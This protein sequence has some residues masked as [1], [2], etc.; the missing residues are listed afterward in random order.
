MAAPVGRQPR[1]RRRPVSV[2]LGLAGLLNRY[3]RPRSAERRRQ[4]H[5]LNDGVG[6]DPGP[7]PSAAD[8]AFVAAPMAGPAPAPGPG[9]A[10]MPAPGP[11][12]LPMTETASREQRLKKRPNTEAERPRSLSQ[13]GHLLPQL[14]S[15]LPS[16]I[17][18][19]RAPHDPAKITAGTMEAKKRGTL[20]GPQAR[21]SPEAPVTL[22]GWLDKQGSERLRLWKTRWFVLSEYCLY[23]Y[24]DAREDKLLGS[25][26]LPSYRVC[27]VSAEDRVHRKFSFR[28]E[29]ANM[30]TY[31]FACDTKEK[32]TE[33][34]NAIS[35]ASI[36]QKDPGYPSRQ[37]SDRP[38]VGSLEGSEAGFPRRHDLN[39]SRESVGGRR[40]SRQPLYANAPPKPRRLT[41]S[42]EASSSPEP[43]DRLADMTAGAP[44]P[45]RR[46]PV[47]RRTP[48]AYAA[49][50][51][52]ARVDYED[53]YNASV[54]SGSSRD[55]SRAGEL[56]AHARESYASSA[57]RST[58]MSGELCTPP[59]AAPRG[60]YGH[61][62]V[63]PEHGYPPVDEYG[64]G[65]AAPPRPH[66][67]DFLEWERNAG[68][69]ASAGR[70]PAPAAR[71]KSSLAR[72]Q[73]PANDYWSEEGYAN[74][75][76]QAAYSGG[77]MLPG[78]AGPGPRLSP[79]PLPGS[80]AGPP[81]GAATLPGH[82]A[83]V[84]PETPPPAGTHS[85]GRDLE[86]V[87]RGSGFMR[88]ASAR[89]ARQKARELDMMNTSLPDDPND[90]REGT[91]RKIQQREE[92]MKRLLEWKQRMLQ[93]PLTRKSPKLTD[94]AARFPPDQYKRR[95]RQELERSEGNRTP[96]PQTVHGLPEADSRDVREAEFSPP[97]AA[98]Q[99]Y[100]NLSYRMGD[101]DPWSGRHE[102]PSPA[103]R[104]VPVV[105]S[106][107]ETWNTAMTSPAH[108]QW[109]ASGVTSP[110]NESWHSAGVSSPGPD[111]WPASVTSPTA[112]AWR[113]PTPHKPDNRATA[114]SHDHHPRMKTNADFRN[115]D[116]S[117]GTLAPDG[118]QQAHS[119]YSSQKDKYHHELHNYDRFYP[120]KE[121]VSAQRRAMAPS[122]N[123]LP[124][125]LVSA[126]ELEAAAALT[127]LRR[128]ENASLGK[129]SDSG[130]DTLRADM[131]G[132]EAPARAQNGR[133]SA[134]RRSAPLE[135][136]RRSAGGGGGWAAADWHDDGD[137]IDESRLVKEFSYEYVKPEQPPSAAKVP[138]KVLPKRSQAPRENTAAAAESPSQ[139]S[140]TP[141]KNLVQE[142][143]K[144][145]KSR[146][147]E[148][149]NSVGAEDERLERPL[150]P[151]KTQAEVAEAQVSQLKM[152]PID[153]RETEATTVTASEAQVTTIRSLNSSSK[154]ARS[155]GRSPGGR[156]ARSQEETADRSLTYSEGSPAN[157]L[158]LRDIRSPQDIID[159]RK[160][161]SNLR[162]FALDEDSP[163]DPEP[164]SVASAN[165]TSHNEP[166]APSEP[167]NTS[168]E[169][170]LA[171]FESGQLSHEWTPSRPS[172]SHDL[173]RVGSD[174]D[175]GDAERAG[176]E[177]SS[178][179]MA[180]VLGDLRRSAD[181]SAAAETR[182][183][184]Q[185]T[186]ESHWSPPGPTDGQWN[187]PSPHAT[188]WTPSGPRTTPAAHWDPHGSSLVP[189]PRRNGRDV[190]PAAGAAAHPPAAVDNSGMAVTRFGPGDGGVVLAPSPSASQSSRR[191]EEPRSPPAVP[192]KPARPPAP[193]P[194]SSPI[195]ANQLP[196]GGLMLN[197]SAEDQYLVMSPPRK[198]AE[199]LSE[200]TPPVPS[201]SRQTSAASLP[202]PPAAPPP[203]PP[204]PPPLRPPVQAAGSQQDGT[205][206]EMNPNVLNLSFEASQSMFKKLSNH[207]LFLESNKYSEVHYEYMAP[208]GRGEPVYMEVPSENGDS[209]G[210][211]SPVTSSAAPTTTTPT[212]AT[213]SP[214]KTPTAENK[215]DNK[216]KAESGKKLKNEKRKTEK[217][218]SS[219][220]S[221][222]SDADDEG[223]KEPERPRSRRFSLS[224]TFRPASYYLQMHDDREQADSS[225]SDL[226]SPP[227]IPMSP[228]PM[229]ELQPTE[230][231]SGQFSYDGTGESDAPPYLLN[232]LLAAHSAQ[233]TSVGGQQV[234]TE[235]PRERPAS[236]SSQASSQDSLARLA[237][238]I[239]SRRSQDSGSLDS[240]TI[241]PDA[242]PPVESVRNDKYKRRPVVD[243]MALMTVAE[244]P[245]VL[246]SEDRYPPGGAPLEPQPRSLLSEEQYPPQDNGGY[247]TMSSPL[248]L[249]KSVPPAL[250]AKPAVSAHQTYENLPTPRTRKPSEVSIHT[251]M[252]VASS[253]GGHFPTTK[254]ESFSS[255]TSIELTP[256]KSPEF[257]S[258]F[259]R[260][261]QNDLSAAAD[262]PPERPPA[263]PPPGV[264]PTPA[265]AV[266]A[267][268]PAPAPPRETGARPRQPRTQL[269]P[270][271][272]PGPLVADHRRGSSNISVNSA[273]STGSDGRA[274]YYYSD[275]AAAAALQERPVRARPKLNNQRELDASKRADI[276][277][278]VNQISSPE[279][280]LAQVGRLAA[281]L[282][283]SV[284]YLE[285]QKW[286]DV[287]ERN[288]YD[289]DTLKK[290]RRRSHT[291]DAIDQSVRNIFPDGLRLK[292]DDPGGPPL[293]HHRRTRSLEG[294]LEETPRCRPP[295]PRNGGR[296]GSGSADR[297]AL[298]RSRTPDFLSSGSAA[299]FVHD[300]RPRSHT[301]DV[302]TSRR[303]EPVATNRADGRR[304]ITPRVEPAPYRPEDRPPMPLPRSELA[305]SAG[306]PPPYRAPPPAD[307]PVAP[308]VAAHG[309]DAYRG[310]ATVG[311]G[312]QSE[313]TRHS[314]VHHSSLR[315][316]HSMESLAEPAPEGS[317]LA[318]GALYVNE[319]MRQ[320][321]Q[322]QQ[323]AS[324]LSSDDVRYDR[325]AQRSD[326]LQRAKHGRTYLEQ[327]DWD[328]R[329]EQFR[330]NNAVR[331]AN[332]P[333]GHPAAQPAASQPFLGDGLPPSFEIDREELRQWDLMSSAPLVDQRRRGRPKSAPDLSRPV[334]RLEPAARR[335]SPA[336]S[337]PPATRLSPGPEPSA[338]AADRETSSQYPAAGTGTEGAAS[339]PEPQD[340]TPARRRPVNAL[341]IHGRCR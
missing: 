144:A 168:V 24:K 321:F 272:A 33:W 145:F 192:P 220:D 268:A 294:L 236:L 29:H 260:T 12:T 264:P 152:P 4:R 341:N 60:G 305:R 287:D 122:S 123:E 307:S 42:R 231:T 131:T 322:E 172:T 252:S 215:V 213:P 66:S 318:R 251:L 202:P 211:A 38:S 300:S 19:R 44:V 83:A 166:H 97:P 285:A 109:P 6:G 27:P 75:M 13:L 56:R 309:T 338:A 18:T 331:S 333:A 269:S 121:K 201:H 296:E 2:D 99:D 113:G 47:E 68:R 78:G 263:P 232:A 111:T 17:G 228:P 281:Q 110:S 82:G 84:A 332:L 306:E 241:R 245:H 50:S 197:T 20:R 207:G 222:A 135:S 8:T 173:R 7:G 265:A 154:T 117:A 282:R 141:P 178:L 293:S 302:L 319:P 128:P 106:H 193:S 160:S 165:D 181:R 235:L 5:S 336:P 267:P 291:P 259:A 15:V 316:A 86:R 210:P 92:S 112:E 271:P 10:P 57:G 290:A 313:R 119:Q 279:D 25:I 303:N 14:G 339:E 118:Y 77:V 288:V 242:A 244:D 171:K 225:D 297:A 270:A 139:P 157:S 311:D 36:M 46:P 286:S 161:R 147:D 233:M 93:S 184:T 125:P 200:P 298:R 116:K 70:L 40:D 179:S 94:A 295:L 315:H 177:P 76:R 55:R 323:R 326:T 43:C 187:T 107:R 176:S 304:S 129:H 230:P 262:R 153:F 218:S 182:V 26:T 101:A 190:S 64:R 266:P 334:T 312:W 61:P 198:P 54:G 104:H 240:V 9:A 208:A 164:R 105:P 275:L 169:D 59:P 221:S 140:E 276:G 120:A 195:Y 71:P 327:Y 340:S 206:M 183:D 203:P 209:A 51:P 174:S 126:R 34:M 273:T 194:S 301:P 67:A 257:Q 11:S 103:A 79:G 52:H 23:Y 30:R 58:Q 115:F 108:E 163:T 308:P 283:N 151:M 227:P 250:P 134:S 73:P 255:L 133:A 274:P 41:G 254:R 239:V 124:P 246:R 196:S 132:D 212:A 3:L 28:I 214:S 226:V 91:R 317:R 204:L 100:V 136:G 324:C 138:P 337:V 87:P 127:D 65:T 328:D 256:V 89:F 162:K 53:V 237:A 156:E 16:V 85:L 234:V 223:S 188:P 224:D 142:R 185:G 243:E 238:D 249:Q 49:A 31:Y 329:E 335:A 191:S 170:L 189:E 146:L 35:L 219:A 69:P 32:M 277:R 45:G 253:E 229:D 158:D 199:A 314:S 159:S 102:V 330:P 299:E 96:R 62:G 175:A 137:K 278:K 88:S 95:V 247:M 320:R 81:P 90:S 37:R 205:Y 80:P 1:G 217:K 325:L 310:G 98:S 292:D 114:S 280:R 63:Y 186:S 149:G 130:Y 261:F 248:S 258:D 284:E 72:Y 148:S 39:T 143:I 74:K 21:R 48:D 216:R 155:P 150:R 289:S 22:R 167:H 180:G